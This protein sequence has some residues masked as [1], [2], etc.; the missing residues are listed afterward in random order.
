MDG[1]EKDVASEWEGGRT[2]LSR[3]TPA[4]GGAL[5]R[6]RRRT[7]TSH[8]VEGHR[9][10]LRQTARGNAHRIVPVECLGGSG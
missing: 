10:G 3:G 8:L 9:R 5:L 4:S 1:A 7:H 6:L 2:Y